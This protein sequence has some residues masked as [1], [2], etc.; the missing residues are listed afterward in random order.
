MFRHSRSS[1]F[2]WRSCPHLHD[3]GRG[4]NRQP[5]LFPLGTLFTPYW[6]WPQHSINIFLRSMV[7]QQGVLNSN[8]ER[9]LAEQWFNH[10]S[11]GVMLNT[12][13]HEMA[14]FT[15]ENSFT[16]IIVRQQFLVSSYHENPYHMDRRT[17]LLWYLILP[18]R[19]IQRVKVGAS[20][21]SVGLHWSLVLLYVVEARRWHWCGHF[22][23]A[24]R[25]IYYVYI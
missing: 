20:Y 7:Y 4:S 14:W 13:I 6:G 18:R 10:V 5:V 12:I 23:Q 19:E 22:M 11:M 3:H 9:H 15:T 24:Y 8:L 2:L 25:S 21:V 16:N 1:Q 17:W